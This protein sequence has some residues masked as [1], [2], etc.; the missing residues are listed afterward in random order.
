MTPS[1]IEPAIVASTDEH[2]AEP[3]TH[4]QLKEQ[5]ALLVQGC[6]SIE[7]HLATGHLALPAKELAGMQA[8]LSQI[9]KANTPPRE[10]RSKAPAASSTPSAKLGSFIKNRLLRG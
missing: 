3:L 5:L 4:A 6:K 7:T 10:K 9:K 1:K 2:A 8:A